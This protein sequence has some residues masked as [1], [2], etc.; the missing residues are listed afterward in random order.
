MSSMKRLIGR[1]GAGAAGVTFGLLPAAAALA[2]AGDGGSP[3]TTAHTG[4]AVCASSAA[5]PLAIANTPP[6]ARVLQPPDSSFYATGDPIR[7]VDQFSC[8]YS[9][10]FFCE[11][12]MMP[13]I[14][15]SAPLSIAEWPT[16]VTEG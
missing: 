16:A 15:G 14:E 9:A 8:G 11:P 1:A 3:A 12:S 5:Q 4:Q 10:P 13:L 2:L 7:A 6:V